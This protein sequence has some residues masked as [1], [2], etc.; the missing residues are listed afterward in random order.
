MSEKEQGDHVLGG[1]YTRERVL[2]DKASR[3]TE[4]NHFINLPWPLAFILSEVAK[5]DRALKVQSSSRICGKRGMGS[6][7]A[8]SSF[9]PE[10]KGRAEVRCTGPSVPCRE[11]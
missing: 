7:T 9:E 8:S 3:V 4:L 5:H 11:A 1:E 2:V 10:Y 6:G